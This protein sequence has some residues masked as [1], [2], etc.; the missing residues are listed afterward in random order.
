[1]VV[2]NRASIRQRRGWSLVEVV[3]VVTMMAILVSL[4]VPIFRR[5]LE[6]AQA[7][8]AAANLRAVWSAERI[9]WLENHVYSSDLNELQAL[10]L[11]DPALLSSSSVYV[12]QLQSTSATAFSATASRT[13]STMWSGT[14][15]V[16]Q[17]G[18]FSGAIM[19]PGQT[20]ITP[21][22]Q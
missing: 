3:V 17:S 12:Y 22:F 1:M 14:L 18:N 11:L 8:I 6:Q 21:G 10:G 2:R 20:T 5:A 4:S 9:Y 16:D 13:G 15:S 19:A 7:D